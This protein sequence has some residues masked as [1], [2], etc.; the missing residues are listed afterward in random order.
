[1]IPEKVRYIINK[2]EYNGY[3][4]YAVGGC[5]RDSILGVTPGDWDITTAALPQEIQEVFSD[6][7]LNLKG[8]KHGTVGVIYKNEMFEVT[9]YRIDGEYKDNRHPQQVTFTSSLREDL[10]RRDFTVNAMAMDMDGSIYDV[11]GG[12]RDLKNKC[13]RCVGD[14]HKRFE[15][16]ALRILRGI[17]FASMEGFHLEESTLLAANA[18]CQNLNGIAYERIYTE[19]KKMLALPSPHGV[20]SRTLPV[21]KVILPT[22]N[23][24]KWKEVTDKIKSLSDG[25]LR[26][27]A[28]LFACD[29]EAELLRLKAETKLKKKLL[30]LKELQELVLLPDVEHLQRL[31]ATNSREDILFLCAFKGETEIISCAHK[32]AEGVCSISELALDGD[33]IKKAGYHS[34]K[35]RLQQEFL[36]EG[37]I[38]QKCQ[39]TVKSLREYLK[40]NPI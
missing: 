13:I 15:E 34:Y 31:M 19:L 22:L 9:T 29:T 37:V 16:D 8:L 24:S 40:K 10:S 1:M 5:V 14:P 38:S 11:F 12:K 26:L 36:L 4:A 21:F 27:A 23:E 7:R 39:N 2:L 35:I 6:H 18:L 32:A 33:A 20:M 25:E 3:P 28:L 17:R 30:R